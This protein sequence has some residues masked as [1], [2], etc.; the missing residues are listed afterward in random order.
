MDKDQWLTAVVLAVALIGVPIGA[1]V[2][3]SRATAPKDD[4]KSDRDNYPDEHLG[5]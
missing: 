5:I 1:L 2:F 4:R 3:I